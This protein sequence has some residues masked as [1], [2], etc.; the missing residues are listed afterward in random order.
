M[1]QDAARIDAHRRRVGSHIHQCT[2]RTLLVGGEQGISLAQ[3]RNEHFLHLQSGV[4][5]TAAYVGLQRRACYD[6]DE[7]GFEH[8]SL[9]PDGVDDAA[10]A[11]GELLRDN[12]L[13]LGIGIDHAAVGVAHLVDCLGREEF[14]A[15]ELQEYP[16]MHRAQRLAA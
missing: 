15:V 16:V 4:I 14:E 5:H 2:A 10:A 12:L 6:V 7:V 1:T 8:L 11:D 3:G 9:H 13:Y